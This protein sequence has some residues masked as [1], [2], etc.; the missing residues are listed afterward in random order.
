VSTAVPAGMRG[1]IGATADL[2]TDTLPSYRASLG[3]VVKELADTVNGQHPQG[4]DLDGEVGE[5]FFFYDASDPAG[6]LRV[7]IDDTDKIA[8]ASLDVGG[9]HGG[10]ATALAS[11]GEVEDR[12]Q[13]LVNN[14]GSE[15]ASVKRLA[16]NQAALTAQVDGNRDQLAGVNLDEEMVSL[17][18]AQRAYEA[19]SRVMTT[20]DDMLDTLINRTG[21]VGR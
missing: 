13:R 11:T 12:Y 5:P 14:L 18:S 17:V 9:L 20:L 19:A 1:E 21:L 8:A 3:A 4:L 6:T 2:L 10:N 15:V 16:T 7:L